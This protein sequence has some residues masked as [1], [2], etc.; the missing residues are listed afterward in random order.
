MATSVITLSQHEIN[1][2]SPDCE[3]WA[4]HTTPVL[5]SLM[6]STGSYSDENIEAQVRLLSDYVIPNLGPRPSKAHTTSYL[7]QSGSPFQPNVN[8]SSDKPLF[9][10]CWEV[11]GRS[12]GSETDPFAV[13]ATHEILHSLSTSL[14]F[15][16]KWTDT[17]Q[18]Q[19]APS[20]EEAKV[21]QAELPRWLQSFTGTDVEIP[22]FTRVPFCFVAFDTKESDVAVKAYFNPKS[23]EIA[24]GTSSNQLALQALRK[25][26]PALKTNTITIMEQSVS[27]FFSFIPLAP[28]PLK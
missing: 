3:Y 18:A 22:G 15:S 20:R 10:Y 19:L 26:E 6:R 17:L 2:E 21:V 11:L 1:S 23:K 7:T 9:R 8:F 12:G 4:R 27:I 25:L 5:K 13:D 16:T 14:G 24:T 28:F